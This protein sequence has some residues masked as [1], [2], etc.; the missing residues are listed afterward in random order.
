MQS[1]GLEN[2]NGHYAQE[3]GPVLAVEGLAE[4]DAGNLCNG[5]GLIGRLERVGEQ[6]LFL[7][8]L[9]GEFRINAGAPD[10]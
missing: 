1:D 5:V 2:A 7:Q 8:G 4:L 3:S 10:S 6:V 9:R